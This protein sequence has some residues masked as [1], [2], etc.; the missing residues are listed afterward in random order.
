MS[1]NFR[2]WIL[3]SVTH[4]YLD[5][6]TL[7]AP[8]TLS[9]AIKKEILKII[10]V[11]KSDLIWK[12]KLSKRNLKKLSN[13]KEVTL[14]TSMWWALL[15]PFRVLTLEKATWF[16]RCVVCSTS[17]FLR[18]MTFIPGQTFLAVAAKFLA[19]LIPSFQK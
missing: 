8:T 3:E 19:D 12:R 9:D 1:V 2:L 11:W 17:D 4:W 13:P 5:T 15:M 6:F 18:K 16:R 10:S 7:L 14:L